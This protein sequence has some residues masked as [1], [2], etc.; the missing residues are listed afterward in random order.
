[1]TL[2]KNTLLGALTDNEFVR[3]I[4]CESAQE[5]WDKLQN[6]H[7][8]DSKIKEAKLQHHRAHYEGLKMI[9]RMQQL[10][11]TCLE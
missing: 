8:G 5:V 10:N 3:V 4:G 7:E 6:T 1:M 9:E 2:A 11:L